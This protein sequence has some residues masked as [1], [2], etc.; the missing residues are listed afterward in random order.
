KIGANAGSATAFAVGT[1]DTIDA[2]NNA[3]WTPAL[4]ANGAALNAFTVKARDNDGALSATAVQTQVQVN[5]VNDAP[6]LTSFAAAI[7]TTNEDTEVELTFAE[8]AAQGNEA[9]VD[10][11]VTAFVVQAVSTGTSPGT[12]T[13][14]A[15]GTNDTIDATNN[16]YWTP[17]QDANGALNAFTVK[18]QDN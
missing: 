2:A 18:A 14:F 15:V 1:N 17:A 16:A 10:G 3:Y 4:N 9:D 5:A 13:A 12:A 8:L 7:D 6:T 11:T